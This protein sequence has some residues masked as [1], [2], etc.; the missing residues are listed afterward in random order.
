MIGMFLKVVF[1]AIATY[2]VTILTARIAY[3]NFLAANALLTPRPLRCL[4]LVIQSLALPTL[5]IAVNIK[6]GAD[7]PDYLGYAAFFMTLAWAFGGIA[8][9]S[10]FRGM[11]QDMPTLI[12]TDSNR[13]LKVWIADMVN[14][15]ALPMFAVG[16][17]LVFGIAMLMR[18]GG[19]PMRN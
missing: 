3:N 12:K 10:P 7:T 15:A 8:Q 18:F 9:T 19:R 5:A 14:V 6:Y 13:G 17:L 1:I 16:A 11:L 4:W 2:A